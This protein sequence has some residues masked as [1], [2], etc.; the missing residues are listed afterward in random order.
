MRIKDNRSTSE[1]RN[2]DDLSR[3][4]VF[5]LAEGENTLDVFIKTSNNTNGIEWN[6]FNLTTE[7]MYML[8]GTQKCF[9]LNAYLVIEN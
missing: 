5:T 8:K 2:F 7:E 6:A 4:N 3:G 9:H 1:V